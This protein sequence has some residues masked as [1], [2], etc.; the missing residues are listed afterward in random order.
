MPLL[1][2]LLFNLLFY[3]LTALVVVVVAIPALM[4]R[5]QRLMPVLRH[6]AAV[7]LWLL[8]RVC[9]IRVRVTGLDHLPA[10]GAA[11]IAAKHQSAFDTIIWLHLLADPCYVLKLELMRIPFW[12]L[13]ARRTEMIA[14]DRKAGG[15]A[16]RGLLLAA[17]RAARDGRQI[18]IFPEG[19]RVAPGQRVPYQPGVAG[20]AAA[21]R[22]P[23]IP[24]ATDSGLCWPRRRFIKT[25]GLVTVAILPPLPTD[26][27]RQALL[28]ALEN[29]I[30]TATDQLLRRYNPVDKPVETLT[31]P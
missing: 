25:P 1:R 31:L 6:Y 7:M 20:L 27:P 4:L 13:L 16:M 15:K 9:G 24:V 22:L 10:S 18:V 28:P 5:R 29:R 26:I 23:V 3:V 30:E 21:L 17:Q 14:V 8:R 11:L 12:G 2:S 19:T